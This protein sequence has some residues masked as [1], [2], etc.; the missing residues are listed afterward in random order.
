MNIQ[1]ASIDNVDDICLM[2]QELFEYIAALQPEYYKKS[3]SNRE[4]IKSIIMGEKA[5]FLVSVNDGAV[6]GF[7]FVEEEKTPS[8]NCLVCHKYAY[9]SD[10]MVRNSFRGKGIG[11]ALLKAVKQWAKDRSLEYL[12]LNVLS[13]NVSAIRMYEREKFRNTNQTMRCKL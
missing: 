11:T 5:D 8:Y 7:A 9:L 10:I 2:Y 3:E 12:E 4:F 13:N 6:M 1:I